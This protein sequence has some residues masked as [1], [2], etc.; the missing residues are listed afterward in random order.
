MVFFAFGVIA[1][2][3]SVP[4]VINFQGRLTDNVNNPISANKTFIFKFYDSPAG[5]TQLPAASPWTET[6]ANIPVTNGVFNV[7]IGS[8]TPIPYTVFQTTNVYMEITVGG[9]TLSPRETLVTSPFAFNANALS[10]LTF[11]A[12]VDTFSVQA[13]DGFKTFNNQVVI[14]SNLI[15]NADGGTVMVPRKSTPGDPVIGTNGMIYYNTLA[16]KFRGYQNGWNDMVTNAATDIIAN[17]NFLQPGAT[18]YVSSGSVQGNLSVYGNV[19]VQGVNYIWPGS[20]S[21]GVLTDDGSGNLT[22]SPAGAGQYILNTNTLQPNST[23]YVTSGTVTG[24]FYALG[25][26]GIGTSAPGA[27]LDINGD[28]ATVLLPRKSTAIDP[29]VA[30]D[31]MIYYNAFTGKFRGRQAGSWSD[32]ITNAATSVIQNQETLQAG[33]TFYVSSGSVQGNL[34]VYG[35]MNGNGSGITN[36]NASNLASGTVPQAVLPSTVAYLNANQLWT[37]PQTFSSSITVNNAVLLGTNNQAVTISSN[38]IVSGALVANNSAGINGY[39]LSSQGP[40]TTPMWVASPAST[41][42]AATNTWTGGNTYVSSSTYNG[43][44]LIST[45]V[46]LQ[47]ST[48]SSGQVLTSGGPGAAAVWSTL[49][50]AALASTQTWTGGN[51]YQSSSTFNGTV[52]VSSN[53]IVNGA[54]VITG[55]GS[56]ITNLTASNLTGIVPQAVLPSTVAYLNANQLW[57]APQTFSSSQTVTAPGGV[58]V[59]YG[60]VAGS[61]TTNSLNMNTHQING[62]SA[63]TLGT[64]AAN[65]QYVDLATNSVTNATTATNLAGGA[66]GSIPYQTGVGA[67]T[68]LAAASD[69]QVIKQAGGVPTWANL[70]SADVANVINLQSTLQSGATFFVSSGTVNNLTVGVSLSLPAASITDAELTSAPT[71]S[72]LINT[73]VKRDG[74]GNFSGNLNGNASTASG[75][76]NLNGGT[77]G[78]LPFQSN[79]NITVFLSSGVAGQVLKQGGS[80]APY[81]ASLSSGDVSNVIT[82]TEVLQ[83]GAT[84]YVSSGTVA[85]PLTVGGNL[86]ASGAV[87]I[88]TT[89]MLQGSAGSS[90]QVFT[91]GGPGAPALWSTLSGAALASTQTWTGGNT[92]Q[93]SSTFNGTVTISSN[94]TVTSPGGLGVTYGVAAGSFTT[95]GDVNVKGLSYNWPGSH[96]NGVLTDNGS[97]ILSW[98]PA[99]AGQYILNSN[100]L[101]TGSTAYP[102]FLYVGTSATVY[103]PLNMT[104]HQINNLAAPTLGTDAANKTYVDAAAFGNANGLL[105]SSNTWTGTETYASSVT[106][107][108]PL[109]MGVTYGISAGS[110]NVNGQNYSWPGSQSNGVLTNNGSGALTWAPTGAGQYILNQNTLQA[111]STFYVTSGTVNGPFTVGGNLVASGAVLISTTV[112]LQ[113]ST[114]SSGQVFT[115]GGPGAAAVW[116]TLTG[117]ALASTQTWTGGNT[118]SSSSTFNGAVVVST[119][120]I[121]QG[122]SGSN[123]QVLTSGGPGA[124]A[125]WSTLTGAALAS[126]QTWTG[127][128]TFVSSVTFS[129]TVVVGNGAGTSGYLLA[130]Q[131]AGA[132]PI[133]IQS[134]A[135]SLL[136]TTNTWT[137]AQTF[138]SSVTISTNLIVN[139]GGIATP[140]LYPLMD[141]TTAL[142]VN[143]ADGVT[144]ILDIDTLNGRF[145]VGITSPTAP[146]DVWGPT[147]ANTE[148]LSLRNGDDSAASGGFAQIEFGWSNNPWYQNFIATRHN[149][150]GAAGNAIDFYTS[151]GTQLGVFPTNA[152]LGMSINNG[153]VGIG[154]LNPVTKLNISSGILTLDGT[155]SG[156]TMVAGSSLTLNGTLMASGSAGTNGNILQSQGPGLP[157]TWITSPASSIL[158]TTNTWSAGNTYASSST[159]NGAVLISTTVVLQGLTGSSGQV[160]T[161]GGP[162]AA[163]TWST[164][165]GAALASTQTWTGGNTYVSS[166]TFNGAVVV[167][168]SIILQGTSGSN[169]QVLTSGG[170]GAVAT[171]STL[172]GAALASTQTWTGGNTFVSSVTFSSTV[173]VG[174]GAG[175]NGYLLA[176]QGAGA[177]PIWIPSP[178]TSLLTTTNTWTAGQTFVSSVTVSS[179]L[180]VNNGGYVGIGTKTPAALLQINA[181]GSASSP[182]SPVLLLGTSTLATSNGEALAFASTNGTYL[183]ITTPAG[184]SGDFLNFQSPDFAGNLYS[185]FRMDQNGSISVG[186]VTAGSNIALFNGAFM[187]G[188]VTGTSGQILQS[189][190]AGTPPTWVS[191]SNSSILSSTNVWTAGQTF[192]SSVTFSSAV[193]ASNG[194]GTSGQVLQSNGNGAAPSWNTFSV[195][196]TPGNTNYIQNTSALQTGATFYVSSGTVANQFMVGVGS[197]TVLTGG[198]V[199][200]GTASPGSRLDIVGAGSYNTDISVNGSIWSGKN[201]DGGGMFVGSASTMFM[202]K[203]QNVNGA[204]GLIFE[205]GSTS[206]LAIDGNGL[207]GIGTTNPATKLH[208]SSGILT[209]DGA[210]SGITMVA[211]SSLT[212]N[213]S[214]IVNSSVGVAGQ[215]LSSQ[216]PGN[217]PVWVSAPAGTPQGADKQIQYN[218]NGVFAGASN[219]SVTGTS[220]TIAEAVGLGA[221]AAAVTISSNLVVAGGALSVGNGAGASGNILQS[222]GPTSAP[223][224]ITSPATSLLTTTNTWTAGQTFV[225]SV[226]ISSNLIV[227]N[228]GGVGIGTTTMTSLLNFPAGTTAAGGINFGDASA[229]LYRSSAGGLT[230]DASLV[231]GGAGGLEIQSGALNMNGGSI[232]NVRSISGATTGIASNVVSLTNTNLT[233]GNYISLWQNAS[234]FTANGLLMNFAAGSGSF[235]GDFLNFQVNSSTKFVVNSGGNVGIGTA[236]P[237][238]ALHVSSGTLTID[239]NSGGINNTAPGGETVTYGVTAG[240]VNVNGQ[241]YSWPGSQANGVLTNNGSGSLTWAPTGAG[242]YI[243]NQNT[244]QSNS[245]FYVTSGT[246]SGPFAVTSGTITLTNGGLAIT[247]GQLGSTINNNANSCAIDWSKGNTQI[248]TLNGSCSTITFANGLSGRKYVLILKQDSS[249]GRT[250]TWGSANARFPGGVQPVLTSAANKTDYLAFMY[251]DI[252]AKYDNLAQTL[253]Y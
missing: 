126:T 165:T 138:T 200:I 72:N 18:F 67:T 203:G 150:A 24:P 135:T 223:T 141:S 206:R 94:V 99:G 146:L 105:N 106:V 195:A 196:M 66:N 252:D 151:D 33:A 181:N 102:D 238:T 235:S 233:S 80:Q 118:Y 194:V 44:V 63:P 157:P 249:G 97:G 144:R 46:V 130:S 247:N 32:L 183:G 129:S 95:A 13:I 241:N 64:D 202:G 188:G 89:V 212:L 103:G 166:S 171:W 251:N 116:S 149:G 62:V 48:G 112:V 208:M 74:S 163:A 143:K 65:K 108:A 170:P 88:S 5:G 12:F 164:L 81:W 220:V 253:N 227:N 180:I 34:Y 142:M 54:G 224:W 182:T 57:T 205:T 175:T 98:A 174:N 209:L 240:S 244:L 90:G 27:L 47:G 147:A 85:G 177:A 137:A 100:T 152:V 61:V 136:T 190:G 117:A 41:L 156:I 161:S 179:N 30:A 243:L 214:L 68:M 70:S 173:V 169:G 211:G 50:G 242:S 140:I 133:W 93:S 231:V 96:S 185:V 79:N 160:F 82:N 207:I 230:T 237:A 216:G 15:V 25:N 123:G 87:L 153:K 60:L 45:T 228:G 28:G 189:A 29:G 36:L 184:Y 221:P 22:W 19:N 127:G 78:A 210:G 37:A 248:I 114:G 225:S 51:T 56:G 193:V 73:I 83:A 159:Y 154:T 3:A 38:L 71:S 172:T 115:S 236:S 167:S 9:E 218:A 16:N 125:T 198:N 55:N 204:D 122:T 20:N 91:S 58:G 11:D 21:N 124:V 14:S 245:T 162:G 75:A 43:A 76:S 226:T 92:Y 110:M 192:V 8:V 148:S 187:P 229:D 107:T 201:S 128:N 176:S 10:G 77:S 49:T 39:L 69:G 2:A 239:G 23:F 215:I 26:V 17:Q 217:T 199:G 168:T 53:L 197:L 219:T 131:G 119:S 35:T 139:R 109:G 232:S 7:Q 1:A 132:A 120:I 246:V 191:A 6:Q 121:L 104:S 155:G 178:A 234:A 250:V 222:N 158:T 42:L 145:G 84:F 59:T 52:L 86:V 101:Q 40:G 134:P 4:Q 111:N 213:G 113:G 31:G 186:A